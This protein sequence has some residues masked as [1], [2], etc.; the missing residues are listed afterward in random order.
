M[1]TREDIRNALL[2]N[3]ADEAERL[4]AIVQTKHLNRGISG[5]DRTIFAHQIERIRATAPEVESVEPTHEPVVE[6][7]PRSR[8]RAVKINQESGDLEDA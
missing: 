8:S 4:I 5:H 7:K 1:P 2:R 3:D 6:E